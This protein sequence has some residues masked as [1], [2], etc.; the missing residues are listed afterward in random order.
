[1]PRI[2]SQEVSGSWWEPDPRRMHTIGLPGCISPT[3][4]EKMAWSWRGL[5]A[6]TI[7]C[8]PVIRISHFGTD[9][10]KLIYIMVFW[11]PV[12]H[13]YGMM[14][15]DEWH[16]TLVRFALQNVHTETFLEHLQTIDNRMTTLLALLL[17]GNNHQLNL[18]AWQRSWTFGLG[19]SSLSLCTALRSSAEHMVKT[20][21]QID[22]GEQRELHC[23][24]H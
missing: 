20:T 15:A 14:Q 9:A 13:H 2:R 3:A 23:C 6:N 11:L 8:R 22:L 10:S 21:F 24:W 19:S 1:M 16:A 7:D 5:L 12:V 18:T 4:R 17:G